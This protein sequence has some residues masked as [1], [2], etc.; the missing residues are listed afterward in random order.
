MSEFLDALVKP[1]V[2]DPKLLARL[3]E[4]QSAKWPNNLRRFTPFK[5][6]R[7]GDHVI[8]RPVVWNPYDRSL[9]VLRIMSTGTPKGPGDWAQWYQDAQDTPLSDIY[10]VDETVI[11]PQLKIPFCQLEK[12]SL[13][14]LDKRNKI[15]QAFA[16]IDA[17]GKGNPEDFMFNDMVIISENART[18]ALNRVIAA[19]QQERGYK[20]YMKSLLHKFVHNGGHANALACLSFRQGGPKES[21]VG[22][23]AKKPGPKSRRELRVESRNLAMGVKEVARRH[24]VRPCDEMK[25]VRALT[26]YWAQKRKSLRATYDLMVGEDYAKWPA[27]LIPSQGAFRY[28]ATKR[29]IKEYDLKVMRNGRRLSAQYNDARAGQASHL[30]QGV[31]EIVDVDG[32]VAKIAVAARIGNRVESIHMTVM[33]AVSRLSGALLGYELAIKGENAEAFR[34]CIASIFL[35]KK[36]RAEELGLASTDGLLCGNIDGIFIDNGAGAS[37][38]VLVAACDEMG[39]MRMLPAP[40]R[41]DLKGVGEGVNSLMVLMMAEEDSGHTRRKDF[42]SKEIRRLKA[43]DKPIPLERFERLFLKAIQHYNN[44]TNKRRLRTSA[45]RKAGIAI[46]PAAIFAYTQMQRR[47]DGARQLTPHEVYERFIPWH[48]RICR[49]GLVFFM[50]MRYTSEELVGFFDEHAKSPGKVKPLPVL[51]KRLD[52]HAN[53]LLWKKPDGSTSELTLVD[54][55]ER[56]IGNVTW[57]GLELLNEDD[58]RRESALEPARRKSRGRLTVKQQSLVAMAESNR[59]RDEMGCLEGDTIRGARANA[60]DKRNL[61]RG[62]AQAEAYG[63]DRESI[64]VPEAA[65]A[66]SVDRTPLIE[67]SYLQRLKQRW[68]VRGN[69]TKRSA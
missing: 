39:L 65:Q 55:D 58:A 40:G 38:E 53:T 42:L 3:L 61:A 5:R 46:T 8:Y 22:K 56:S 17:V 36:E 63:T 20:T 28:H 34:R 1:P 21:R 48:E 23:N 59:A 13:K 24:P 68:S 10:L 32:F 47:G 52:G 15:L 54:E 29:L 26:T 57:K 12:S 11:P 4:F 62:A 18:A 60:E 67:A 44:F 49:R 64:G 37:E 45:M 14:G 16:Y 31:I 2:A 9:H 66:K 51:V 35:S 6:E 19:L 33:L 69:D 41:G 7:D 27:R 30:T 25:F 43:K 50:S